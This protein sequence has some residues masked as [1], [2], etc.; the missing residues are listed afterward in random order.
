[1]CSRRERRGACRPPLLGL[2]SS[3]WRALPGRAQPAPRTPALPRSAACMWTQDGPVLPAATGPALRWYGRRAS[4]APLPSPAGCA[5]G[6]RGDSSSP[7]LAQREA[8]GP[9]AGSWP[10]D[11]GG[12]KSWTLRRTS[13]GHLLVGATCPPGQGGRAFSGR[14]IPCW[15]PLHCSMRTRRVHSLGKH[16]AWLPACAGA[17]Q[18]THRGRAAAG[19]QIGVQEPTRQRHFYASDVDLVV[20][21]PLPGHPHPRTPWGVAV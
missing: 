7:D 20:S 11:G 10:R 18:R 9:C 16:W 17:E 14:G 13:P 2:L 19:R 3:L 4:W 12:Q 6:L 1:M 21:W 8:S 15:G 5:C